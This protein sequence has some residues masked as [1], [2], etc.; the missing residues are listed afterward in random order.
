[1]PSP[2]LSLALTTLYAVLAKTLRAIPAG[3]VILAL[4][5][6]WLSLTTYWLNPADSVQTISYALLLLGAFLAIE[7][8]LEILIELPRHGLSALLRARGGKE[9]SG[10]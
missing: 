4:S 2:L 5:Y 6:I 1:M 3:F 9:P 10:H 8:I 7:S